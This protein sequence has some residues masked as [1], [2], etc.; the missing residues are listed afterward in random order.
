M[1]HSFVTKGF[2]FRDDP[3]NSDSAVARE[4]ASGKSSAKIDI[5]GK[6]E[7]TRADSDEPIW[8]E[9]KYLEDDKP[10]K[11]R[12]YRLDES[13]CSCARHHVGMVYP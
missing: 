4:D 8:Y 10:L 13:R 7:N 9:F 12:R 3:V 2:K 5:I 6:F 1:E 11:K